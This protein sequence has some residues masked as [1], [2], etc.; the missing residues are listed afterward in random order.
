MC[1]LWSVVFITWFAAIVLHVSNKRRSCL[2]QSPNSHSIN[3]N[4]I[5]FTTILGSTGI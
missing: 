5:L 4:L 3:L 1:F 2:L